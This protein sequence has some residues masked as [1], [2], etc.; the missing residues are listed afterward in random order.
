M[1][2]YDFICYIL[3]FF[4][5]LIKFGCEVDYAV[6]RPHEL[7]PE[8]QHRPRGEKESACDPLGSYMRRGC[9]WVYIY[10]LIHPHI[11]IADHITYHCIV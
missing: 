11:D 6:V 2:L 8:I 10:T 3:C 1:K 7:P 4:I 5:E 9:I